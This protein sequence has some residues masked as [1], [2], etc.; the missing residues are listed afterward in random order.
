MAQLSGRVQPEAPAV[1]VLIVDD[2]VAH[3]RA[4]CDTLRQHHFDP[5]GH[6]TPDAALAALK[7]TRC[8]L[9]L[10]DLMMPGMDGIAFLREA[11]RLDPSLVGIIM[12]GEGTVATAVEAMKAGALDYILKPFRLNVVLPVLSRALAVRRLR[13]ENQELERRLRERTAELEVANKELEAFSYSVSHD[14]RAPL[15]AVDGFSSILQQEFASALPAEARA[16]LNHVSAGAKRMEHLIEDML[17]FSQLGRQALSK[18]Q[19]DPNGLVA[20]VI[21]QLRTSEDPHRS[22]DVHVDSLPTVVADLALLRQVFVN[23]L[24]NAFKFTRNREIRRIDVGCR[25]LNGT[26]TF[27]VRDNGAGF[28]MRYADRLFGVFQRF[29]RRDEYE[30][31]GVGLSIVQRIVQR[32][33]GR[34]WAEAAVD[35]GATFHFTLDG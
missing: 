26:S 19:V 18:V 29:H 28:D 20:G 10:A 35:Q 6:S 24:S 9:L 22:V 4:L 12:T 32:H 1:R 23:L 30:G 8:E 31:S 16:L 13:L 17:R 27:F 21:D 2:E 25:Q 7:D 5:V 15:R 3:V 14:L 33:G 11:L 34:I